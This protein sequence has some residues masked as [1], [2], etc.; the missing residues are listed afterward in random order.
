MRPVFSALTAVLVLAA[1]ADSE[2]PAP[3]PATPA[4]AP[5]GP[6]RAVAD[7]AEVAGSGVSGTVR[8]TALDD[9]VEIRYD[10]AGLAAGEHGFH[11]HRTGDCGA[12]STGTPAGAAGGHFNP[13]TSEHGAPSAARTD[14]HAGDLGNIEAGPEGRAVGVRVDSVLAFSGPTSLVGKAVIV[15]AGRDDLESQPSGAAGDR[16]AC[17]VIASGDSE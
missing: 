3:P 13:L 5:S 4:P 12:D 7:L 15:H 17:G 16:V 6:E 8:F 2:A 9:A 11:V 1:C 10:L 14:R